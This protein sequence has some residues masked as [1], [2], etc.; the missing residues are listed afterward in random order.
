MGVVHKLKPEVINFIVENKKNNP[1]LSCRSLTSLI[2]EKLNIRVSKSSINAIFKENNLS[3][4]IG[5]RRTK[6][7]KK[8]NMPV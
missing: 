7:K 1:S 6:S 8:F 2:F 3:M 4:P 5:R